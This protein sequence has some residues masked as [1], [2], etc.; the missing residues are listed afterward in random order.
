WHG[1][2]SQGVYRRY[3]ADNGEGM[4]PD[5]LIAF[6]SQIGESGKHVGTRWDNLGWG[7]KLNLIPWNPLGV[8]IASYAEP[9]DGAV[10]PIRKNP[11][12]YGLRTF[13]TADGPTHV[14]EPYFDED[15]GVDLAE[16]GPDWVREEGGTVILCVGSE[17]YPDTILGDPN[18]EEGKT[19]AVNQYMNTRL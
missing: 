17:E 12:G 1:V 4:D 2:A 11:D 13:E 8:V 15:L 18:K 14:V 10:I 19:K 16:L 5:E 9:W 6:F 7:A 3:I